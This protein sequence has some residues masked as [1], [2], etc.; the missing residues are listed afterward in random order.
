MR[1]QT[2]GVSAVSDV[3]ASHEPALLLQ[4]WRLAQSVRR[5][6]SVPS[7]IGA[8]WAQR[9]SGRRRVRLRKE[10]TWEAEDVEEMFSR[11]L[12]WTTGSCL[13]SDK[14][15]PCT[16]VSSRSWPLA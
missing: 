1:R 11:R 16:A 14:P 10:G 9:G 15:S 8:V 2:P 13:E 12:D 6:V 5:G 4:F 7:G 3:F